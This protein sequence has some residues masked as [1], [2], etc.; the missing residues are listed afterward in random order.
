MESVLHGAFGRVLLGKRDITIGQAA[1]NHIVIDDASVAACHVYIRHEATGYSITD[2]GASGGTRLNGVQ[3]KSYVPYVL[4]HFDTICIGSTTCLYEVV[5][6]AP[7]FAAT[8]L[9]YLPLF[10]TIRYPAPWQPLFRARSGFKIP[11]LRFSRLL[12]VVVLL[13]IGLILGLLAQLAPVA[14]GWIQNLEA[15]R[16][17]YTY[18][19]ALKSQDYTAAYARLDIDSQRALRL[20]DFIYIIQRP[21]DMSTIVNCRITAIR[22][23]GTLAWGGISYKQS[24]GTTFTI[25]Y[26][27]HEQ[28]HS[29]KISHLVASTSDLL[30]ATYCYALTKQ[31]YALAY[32]LWSTSVRREITVSTFTRKLRL[33]AI[34][35]CT[36]TAAEISATHTLAIIAYTMNH[37][38][39][40][41]YF[42]DLVYDGE[43]WWIDEQRPLA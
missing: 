34:T 12:V 1:N 26:I 27:L 42:V 15:A 4:H 22:I 7:S 21:T 8:G 16:T 36:A 5:M 14:V 28:G 25:N 39:T 11:L 33:S 31:T 29:W 32:T 3:L 2:L 30:L 19:T 41:L 40:Q 38:S 23:V 37:A 10:P 24:D 9:R 6:L 18:C 17:L 20:T 43:C 13:G 35:N